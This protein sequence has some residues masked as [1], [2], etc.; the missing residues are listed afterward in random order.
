[1][2]LYS[3]ANANRKE[4]KTEYCFRFK[5]QIHLLKLP[6]QKLT[7]IFSLRLWE[8]NIQPFSQHNIPFLSQSWFRQIKLKTSFL[9]PRCPVKVHTRRRDNSIP[10][11]WSTSIP[12]IYTRYP[13]NHNIL[14]NNAANSHSSLGCENWF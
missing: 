8:V 4:K 12:T 13:S 1:M 10:V 14:H 3:G 11:Q 7:S 9:N 5:Y 2:Q 6:P